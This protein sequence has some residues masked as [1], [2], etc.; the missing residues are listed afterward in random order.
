LKKPHWPALVQAK[1]QPLYR[2][3]EQKYFFDWFNEH[4]VS[5]GARVIGTFFWK[6]GDQAIIDS[7]VVN[8]SAWVVGQASKV[9]RKAQ[10]GYLY[11]YAFAM[12][13]ALALMLA[14]VIGS[15]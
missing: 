11:H 6:V 5:G 10:S 1:I 3:L 4:I 15:F 7:T 13:I 2:V 8:G 14:W 12:M 9:L